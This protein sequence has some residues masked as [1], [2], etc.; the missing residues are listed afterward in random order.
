M[1]YQYTANGNSYTLP[2]EEV[3]GFLETFP[4]A[5]KNEPGKT[6]PSQE[7]DARVEE[8]NT[9]S[10]LENG[11][12]EPTLEDQKTKPQFFDV[13]K[14]PIGYTG[15]KVIISKDGSNVVNP[16]D[17]TLDLPITLQNKFVANTKE[18]FNNN[19]STEDISKAFKNTIIPK[20]YVLNLLNYAYSEGEGREAGEEKLK[21][22]IGDK[23]KNYQN[24]SSED[25]GEVFNKVISEAIKAGPNNPVGNI[26]Q[27]ELQKSYML[28][29]DITRK[30]FEPELNSIENQWLKSVNG[31]KQKDL[32]SVYGKNLENLQV[33]RANKV[34]ADQYIFLNI[35]KNRFFVNQIKDKELDKKSEEAWGLNYSNLV[36]NNSAINQIQESLVKSV[37]GSI[38]E[39]GRKLRLNEGE[40]GIFQ[41][42]NILGFDINLF[43]EG[44]SDT[45]SIFET[46][47][48]VIEKTGAQVSSGYLNRIKIQPNERKLFEIRREFKKLQDLNDNDNITIKLDKVFSDPTSE[49]MPVSQA[50]KYLEDLQQPIL[51][52]QIKALQRDEEL[53]MDMATYASG[54]SF[55]KEV[56]LDQDYISIMADILNPS[57]M[58]QSTIELGTQIATTAGVGMV[59]QEQG[60]SFK[61]Q[62]DNTI[63]NNEEQINKYLI[64][65]SI[66]DTALNKQI[67]AMELGLMSENSKLISDIVGGINGSLEMLPFGLLLKKVPKKA[68]KQKMAAYVSNIVKNIFKNKNTLAGVTALEIGT[69][70]GQ[71]VVTDFGSAI[72][73]INFMKLPSGML[74]ADGK[75]VYS[76]ESRAKLSKYIDLEQGAQEGIKVFQGILLPFTAGNMMTSDFMFATEK[77]DAKDK[78]TFIEK[79]KK[80]AKEQFEG[81]QI[82]ENTYNSRVKRIDE[83]EKLEKK[84]DPALKGDARIKVANLLELKQQKQK[85]KEGLDPETMQDRINNDIDG[86]NQEIQEIVNTEFSAAPSSTTVVSE[87]NKKIAIKN[88][89]L[90]AI[91]KDPT[92]QE[93][94]N[95]PESTAIE[96]GQAQKK[97]TDAE[98]ELFIANQGLINDVVNKKFDPS[99]DS[100]LEKESLIA[101]AN[102][103][104]LELIKTFTPE[105]GEFGSY[106]RTYLNLR[107]NKSIAKLTGSQK[108]KETGKFEMAP[109]Q[110]I[111]EMEV[112]EVVAEESTQVLDE[113][114]TKLKAEFGLE[115][116]TVGKI[117]EAV[118]KV[119]GTSLPA[120]TDKG[121]KKKV[122]KAFKDELTDLVKKDGIFGKDS[123]E[124]AAFLED[125]AEA[126]YKS[127]PLEVMTKSFSQ[128]TEKQIDPKTGKP[129]RERTEVGKEIFVKKDFNDVKDEFINY[130]TDRGLKSAARSD[131]KTSIATQIAD[132]LARD[133][134]VGVLSDPKVAEKFK[135]VQELEGKKV[136]EDYLDR[137]VREL[138]RGLEWLQKQQQSN[139]LRFSLVVP[140]LAAKALEL[141]LKTFIA[142]LKNPKVQ[143]T[144]KQVGKNT[145]ALSIA[146]KEAIKAVQDK[147]GNWEINPAIEK[148]IRDNVNRT[149]EGIDINEENLLYRLEDEFSGSLAA[150]LKLDKKYTEL[151]RDPDKIKKAVKIFNDSV[152]N[153]INIEKETGESKIADILYVLG[154]TAFG[155]RSTQYEQKKAGKPSP[156]GYTIFNPKSWDAWFNKK[157]KGYKPPKTD[158]YKVNERKNDKE[159]KNYLKIATGKVAKGFYAR[160]KV[161]AADAEYLYRT[162]AKYAIENGDN[163][164]IAM[165]LK[166]LGGPMEGITRLMAPIAYNQRGFKPKTGKQVV[167]EHLNPVS[168]ID[169]MMLAKYKFGININIDKIFKDHTVAIIDK[170][171]AADLNAN[172]LRSNQ[173]KEYENGKNHVTK[174]IFNEVIKKLNKYDS[175]I[176]ENMDTSEI[177]GFNEKLQQEKQSELGTEFN[178]IIEETKGIAADKEYSE[179]QGRNI[180]RKA[181]KLKIFVPYSAEDLLGL[182]YRFA[183]EGK[184]GDAHLKWIKDNISTPLTESF[185]RFEVAQQ[186]ANI[187]LEEAKKLAAESGIDFTKEAV[188]GYT[189]DQAIRIHIWSN[190]GYNLEKLI[191]MKENQVKRINTHIRQNFDIK[192][193][194]SAIKDAYVNNDRKYPPP[195]DRTWISGTI[196]TDLLNFTNSVTR[197]EAFKSFFDNI[198]GIFGTFD[199]NK[200][201][202]SGANL[203]KIKAVYGTKFVKALESSLYRIHTGRNRSYQLDQQG[204]SILNWTN[205]AIGNIMFFNTRS[206]IL[207]TLSN[208]NFTNW[209]DNNPIEVAKAWKNTGQ[210]AKDFTFI[211]NS[212][213]LKSRRSGLKTDINEQEIATAVNSTNKVEAMLATILKKGFL[214]TQ[215]ADSFAIA[216]GGASF[217]RNRTNKYKNDGMSQEEAETQAFKDFREISEDS[218]QSSRPDK[219]SMEQA[220]FAGRLILAFQNTPMQYNRLAKKAMLDL[221]NRRGDTK[222]NVSKVIWYLG[223]Q[224]AVFYASQQAL[225]SIMFDTPETDDEEKREK[226]RYFNLVNGMADSVI[227]GSGVYGALISTS[228]NLIIEILKEDTKE[229][230]VIKALSAISPPINKK[231]RQAFSISKKF[232]YQQELKKMKELGLD[233]KNPA[234]IAGAEALSF[235]INLPADRALK[236]LNNL[237]TAFEE[238]TEW[239][240][241]VALALGWSPYDVNIDEFEKEESRIKTRGLKERSIKDRKIKKRKIK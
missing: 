175:L 71:N 1:K 45:P 144:A 139:T 101:E 133:E 231:V 65:N 112:G 81:G 94:I 28:A 215:M 41:D 230:N 100:G 77:M 234:I 154:K 216:L 135:A 24:L 22:D 14:K 11:S 183:G 187:Y 23:L 123:Q 166:T 124:F 202:L 88:K 132:Q 59:F 209:H 17:E 138:D 206:A 2:E 181:N 84:I 51:Q 156:K 60:F 235:G 189:V 73:E 95:D 128:F 223:V 227:R 151:F 200:G 191:G 20:N 238:E 3:E 169:N 136:P 54:P 190:S 97:I 34:I 140:E 46:A 7:T 213:Y 62:L 143:K 64:D 92:L 8:N 116:E 161:R 106:A 58:A 207:Q 39:K 148:A 37:H 75:P 105:K 70:L 160:D 27:K 184:Q 239:W 78:L 53:R 110:D 127:L 114:G 149:R 5:K 72:A 108:N 99:K 16:L 52:E 232:I 111:T 98:G 198:D 168:Y 56:D 118:T 220:G 26:Y 164:Q 145:T 150:I 44:Y 109:K 167:L 13:D 30:Q 142:A 40:G 43:P 61:D 55:A 38:V 222:T 103:E 199:K 10:N 162:I 176:I 221:I 76:K 102:I 33:D 217:Y 69:E 155:D 188:D 233:S 19:L 237:R 129:F 36:D 113:V 147:Y 6:N 32:E 25:K 122:I 67:A 90:M 146:L 179:A 47:A 130:F 228:K 21:T 236:K 119:F 196:T 87:E 79:I 210:F 157:F 96:K 117:K 86:I 31:R 48:Q 204:D 18:L 205:N 42:I 203:N 137:I 89:D 50:R 66:E 9:A 131:R 226:Q 83:F 214:P 170:K 218:Q 177:F 212:D 163:N 219:I 152:D 4:D 186:S 195:K 165:I 211:F 193:F 185:I 224:N 141:F 225:F 107:L 159:G 182:L 158:K 49:T 208:V 173:S 229:E 172:G 180:G 104:F 201:K 12:S 35:E 174:R 57:A 82:N 192:A 197:E 121:F 240:Q 29:T 178:Q 120:V 63:K 125:N 134:V 115:E 241:S 91:I 126:I 15:E 171:L 68:F 74:L 80:E 85:E 153:I 194:E 93:I